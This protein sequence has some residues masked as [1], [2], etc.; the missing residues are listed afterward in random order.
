MP[1]TLL[2][3]A[4]FWGHNTPRRLQSGLLL[5]ACTFD[6]ARFYVR[7]AIYWVAARPKE[8]F[9]IS[10]VLAYH[11]RERALLLN[12]WHPWAPSDIS[13]ADR[14][15][16]NVDLGGRR[17]VQQALLAADVVWL[18]LWFVVFGVRQPWGFLSIGCWSGFS[19]LGLSAFPLPEDPAERRLGALLGHYACAV[20][21][22]A[23]FIGVLVGG[24]GWCST[25]PLLPFCLVTV[26]AI[27]GALLGHT[28]AVQKRVRLA[29]CLNVASVG[30]EWAALSVFYAALALPPEY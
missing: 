8:A 25:W 27:A 18:S 10:E 2:P 15:H 22:F 12:L 21:V 16:T 3:P 7:A 4:V 13:S 11:Q 6:I 29:A 24:H 19:Y 5:S 30:G 17:R 9:S 14:M 23:G 28:E 26:A 20:G 1:C